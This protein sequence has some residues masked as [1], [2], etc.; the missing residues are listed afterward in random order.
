VTSG[1]ILKLILASETHQQAE[2]I[3]WKPRGKDHGGCWLEAGCLS[4]KCNFRPPLKNAGFPGSSQSMQPPCHK[5]YLCLCRVDPPFSTS[6]THI[7]LCQ[8]PNSERGLGGAAVNKRTVLRSRGRRSVERKGEGRSS[9]QIHQL[10]GGTSPRFTELV[11]P[12]RLREGWTFTEIVCL[13]L[14]EHEA[15][16]K[17]RE[18]LFQSCTCNRDLVCKG[19]KSKLFW[20]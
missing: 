2:N 4:A 13:D 20:Q 11:R 8:L 6:D 12:N 9:V 1:V 14:R 16:R 3:P 10:R 7:N 19:I 18:R 17:I 15:I 5:V